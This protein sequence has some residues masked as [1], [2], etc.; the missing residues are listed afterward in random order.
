MDNISNLRPL[1]PYNRRLPY[2]PRGVSYSKFRNSVYPVDASMSS[3]FGSFSSYGVP[4]SLRGKSFRS[5]SPSGHTSSSHPSS[6]R[7]DISD[8]RAGRRLSSPGSASLTRIPLRSSSSSPS[9]PT[10]RPPKT[11]VTKEWFETRIPLIPASSSSSS[12][13]GS[14]SS[15]SN[16]PFGSSSGMKHD[17][18]FDRGPPETSSMSHSLYNSKSS[19][20]PS[21]RVPSSSVYSSLSDGINS[22]TSSTPFPAHPVYPS[23]SPPVVPTSSSYSSSS[24]SEETE[25]D[26]RSPHVRTTVVSSHEQSYSIPR[27]DYRSSRSNTRTSSI[28]GSSR[29]PEE[30]REAIVISS[31]DYDSGEN[32][33]PEN[34]VSSSKRMR[35]ESSIGEDPGRGKSKATRKT[36]VYYTSYDIREH[37]IPSGRS[38]F[39]E[40]TVDD[41]SHLS[42]TRSSSTPVSFR[43]NKFEDSEKTSD[44]RD[45]S[46]HK[47]P[48]H[49]SYGDHDSKKNEEENEE[50]SPGHHNNI[51][52]ASYPSLPS[53]S[54]SLSPKNYHV[55]ELP[56]TSHSSSSSSLSSSSWPNDHSSSL[57]SPS[58]ETSS[59]T[60]TRKSVP[61]ATVKMYHHRVHT[62]SENGDDS[63]FHSSPQSSSSSSAYSSPQDESSSSSKIPLPPPSSYPRDE[64]DRKHTKK[65]KVS[66]KSI[67][68]I[69]HSVRD[70]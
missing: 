38:P 10:K 65:G 35:I 32:N 44:W 9:Y 28:P 31:K 15:S 66:V 37:P 57:E 27:S 19:L 13:H 62:V 70:N 69:L 55:R 30:N 26:S 63:L 4:Y 12:S 60:D 49:F 2:F 36:P 56:R 48:K 24:S 29:Y 7:R 53:S 34:G 68:D 21:S 42:K 39:P 64:R 5:Y 20:G 51:D 22:M 25:H 43:P 54:S 11:P 23:M 1:V 52:S 3:P 18:S 61:E 47:D 40:D 33:R 46:S 16:F 50:D 17:V 45:N 14:S 67:Q 6:W 59:S 41:D 8:A 58:H